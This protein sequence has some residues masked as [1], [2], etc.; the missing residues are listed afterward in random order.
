MDGKKLKFRPENGQAESVTLNSD[1]SFDY[2]HGTWELAGK[3]VKVAI[4]K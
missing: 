2:A 4:K 3:D 1:G